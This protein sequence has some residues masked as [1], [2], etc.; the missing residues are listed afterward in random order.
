M[1]FFI[2]DHKIGSDPFILLFLILEEVEEKQLNG[3]PILI[4]R[5]HCNRLQTATPSLQQ[6][7]SLNLNLI[8]PGQNLRNPR[9]QHS[10]RLLLG[11]QHQESRLQES[12]HNVHVGLGVEADLTKTVFGVDLGDL[13]LF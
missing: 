5:S 12:Y 10:Q 1:C 7:N 3:I 6:V 8:R 9:H 4:A 2:H 11:V 13:D